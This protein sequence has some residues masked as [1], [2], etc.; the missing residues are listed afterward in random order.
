MERKRLLLLILVI[1]SAVYYIVRVAI[2]YQGIAGNME[3]EETQTELIEGVVSYSFLAI[4]AFGLLFLPGVHMLRQWGLWGTLAVS[5]YT[6]AFDV[7]AVVAVQPSAGA[8][9]V[10]AAV[11]A[12]YLVLVRKDFAAPE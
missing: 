5:A 6:V 12:L 8:G 7:W 3:F 2:F 1:F 11:I 10:P 9:I 4:G